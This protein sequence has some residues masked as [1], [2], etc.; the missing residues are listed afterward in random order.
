MRDYK[1]AYELLNYT[2]I[3]L[4]DYDRE[5]LNDVEKQSLKKFLKEQEAKLTLKIWNMLLL[6]F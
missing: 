1:N 4:E 3:N 2:K 6:Q 5:V